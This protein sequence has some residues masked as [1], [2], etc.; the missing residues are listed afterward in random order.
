[1]PRSILKYGNPYRLIKKSE[2]DKIKT[3]L[4]EVDYEMGEFIFIIFIIII[5]IVSDMPDMDPDEPSS[6]Y[7]SEIENDYQL[8]PINKEAK[9]VCTV[10]VKCE[11]DQLE[12]YVKSVLKCFR[13]PYTVNIDCY[14]LAE[15]MWNHE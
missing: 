14:A 15:N 5:F 2:I 10:T 12:N 9:T 13:Q 11:E 7:L 1:M 8:L 6:R 4:E 3:Y